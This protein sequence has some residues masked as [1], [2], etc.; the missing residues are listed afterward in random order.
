M[1]PGEVIVV[2]VSVLGIESDRIEPFG[3]RLPQPARGGPGP[4]A[5]AAAGALG[6]LALVGVVA[7]VRRRRA[8][9]VARGATSAAEPGEP[10]VVALRQLERAAAGVEAD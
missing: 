1:G 10:W 7:I 9:R 2:V 3:Y 6:T 4:W 5:A 8:G